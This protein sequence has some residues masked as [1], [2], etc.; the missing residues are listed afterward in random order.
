MHFREEKGD[1][2]T[3]LRK[4]RRGPKIEEE[5][6]ISSPREHGWVYDRRAPLPVRNTFSLRKGWLRHERF[7]PGG[8]KEYTVYPARES[9]WAVGYGTY[10]FSQGRSERKFPQEGQ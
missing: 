8:K 7:L 4:E 2:G 1:I 10:R 6:A 3:P 5:N 9:L